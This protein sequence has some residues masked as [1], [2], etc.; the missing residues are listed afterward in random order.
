MI[1][2]LIVGEHRRRIE[3]MHSVPCH[4]SDQSIE[5]TTRPNPKQ[6]TDLKKRLTAHLMCA[7]DGTRR[8]HAGLPVDPIEDRFSDIAIDS[9]V[10][11]IAARL[12]DERVASAFQTDGG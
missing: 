9:V 1:R 5:D 3:G 6:P 8:V 10:V 12:A 2:P 7:N 11:Q 4:A